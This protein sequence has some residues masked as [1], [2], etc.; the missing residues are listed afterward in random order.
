MTDLMSKGDLAL[1]TGITGYMATWIAKDLLDQ[2]YRVRGTY[3]SEAKLPFIKKL[4]PGIELV[5]ADLNGD[6]GWEEALRDVKFLFHVASPQAV[7]TESNRTET[8]INGIDNIFKFALASDSLAKIELT[9]SEAAIA[10][11]KQNKTVYTENDW[12]ND[13][14]KGLDDYMKSKTLEERRAWQLINDPK[15]NP[16]KIPMTTIN[17]SFVI[18]PSLVPWA[19]YSAKQVEQ[20]LN[21]PFSLP[22][23]GYAV[24]VRDVALMQISLM[25]NSKANNTRNLA[26][27]IRM[28]MADVKRYAV[29]DFKDRG[30]HSMQIPIPAWI[31]WPFRSNTGIADFYPR[32]KGQVDYHPLHPEFYQYKYTNLQQSMDD[33]MNQLLNDKLIGPNAN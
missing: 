22:M 29:E 19:R 8:A 24:D 3:R 20:F 23:V 27:G 1:V 4:L 6:D 26:M 15:T 25:N 13:Q 14:A 12:T 11:G 32:L 16:R 30:I 2:G 33:M 18:G 10:Y 17:P 9:S 31:L 5:K 28:S 21:M 7:A